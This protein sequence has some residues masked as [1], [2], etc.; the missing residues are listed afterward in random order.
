MPVLQTALDARSESFR[1]N[2]E[3][4][5]GLVAD[6]KEKLAAIEEGGGDE[7]RRRH[8]ARGKLLAARAGSRIARSGLAVSRTLAARRLRHV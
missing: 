6:L 5:R 2:V 1:S 8:E 7:A 3:R 4:M